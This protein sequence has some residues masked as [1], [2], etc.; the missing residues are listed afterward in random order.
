MNNNE[1]AWVANRIAQGYR[2]VDLAHMCGCTPSAINLA[3]H[4]FVWEFARLT[5][6]D[7]SYYR[8]NIPRLRQHYIMNAVARH[9][10]LGGKIIRPEPATVRHGVITLGR[11]RREHAWRLRANGETLKAIGKR[12]GVSQERAR[13]MIAC[14]GRDIKEVEF[15]FVR[16]AHDA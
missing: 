16:S 11:A 9:L 14:Y 15:R 2:Q 3:L 6:S 5:L 8:D 13:Q 12:L 10:G 4:K 1:R 7:F